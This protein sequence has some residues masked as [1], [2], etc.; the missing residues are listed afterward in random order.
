MGTHDFSGG[1]DHPQPARTIDDAAPQAMRNQLIDVA[2][3]V[4]Q[5]SGGHPTEAQLHQAIGQSLGVQVAGNPMSPRRTQAAGFLAAAEWKRVYDVVLRLVPDFQA[6]GC[7]P[8]YRDGVNAVLAA[9]GVAWDLDENGHFAR[10]LPVAVQAVVAAAIQELGAPEYAAALALFNLAHAAYNDVPRR[11][12]DACANAFDAMESVAK[13]KHNRP[14]DTFGQ[15]VAHVAGGHN[16][17]I[18]GVL[19][20]INQLRNAN[21]GHGVP[22]TLAA[23]EVDFTYLT[24]VA[25]IL[26]FART[27]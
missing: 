3:S 23:A 12:R 26:L 15:V 5:H 22:F 7:F 9:N 27:P 25:G 8:E 10:V 4:T 1:P 21:F 20:R 14:Q 2:F 17:E 18:V 11:D 24:C 19:Q 6:A 13:V 16:A